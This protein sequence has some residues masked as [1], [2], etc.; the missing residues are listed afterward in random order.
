MHYVFIERNKTD[1]TKSPT[2]YPVILWMNGGPK[3]GPGCSSLQGM[4]QE[5]GPYLILQG[6]T[7]F[8]QTPNKYSWNNIANLL[9]L[10]VRLKQ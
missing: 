7:N 5:I 8:S 6:R 1:I 10:E 9:F 4:A 2:D 3:N